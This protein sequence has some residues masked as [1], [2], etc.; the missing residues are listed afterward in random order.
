MTDSSGAKYTTVDKRRDSV[1]YRQHFAAL[2]V[3]KPRVAAKAA[4]ASV[5]TFDPKADVYT[6][7]K[8]DIRF[9]L[10]P[11]KLYWGEFVQRHAVAAD[12]NAWIKE[13]KGLLPQVPKLGDATVLTFDGREVAT[14]RRDAGLNFARLKAEQ[15]EIVAKYTRRVSETKFDKEAFEKDEPLLYALYR[16][17]QLRLVRKAGLTVAHLIAQEQA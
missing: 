10:Q 16:G 17:K 14:Y 13:F 7:A 1:D 9:E 3:P 8:T 15:P 12:M 11:L 2:P 4:S 6:P 5:D